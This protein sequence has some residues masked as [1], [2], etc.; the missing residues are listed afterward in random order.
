MLAMLFAAPPRSY[1]RISAELACPIVRSGRRGALPGRLRTA[2]TG[3]WRTNAL[4]SRAAVTR[5]RCSPLAARRR[6]PATVTVLVIG[7]RLVPRTRDA[8]DHDPGSGVS[9]HVVLIRVADSSCMTSAR[10]VPTTGFA[11]VSVSGRKLDLVSDL[12]FPVT[13]AVLQRI[14][15][16]LSRST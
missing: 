6:E 13:L 14:T 7:S 8:D 11:T 5:L 1:E 10:P 9:S 2:R 12:A 3:A 15:D 4:P 16:L